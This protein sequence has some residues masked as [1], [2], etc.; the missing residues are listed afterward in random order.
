MSDL[1]KAILKRHD[2]GETVEQIRQAEGVGFGYVYSVLREHRP[3][4][5]RQPR[6][7]TSEKRKLILGLLASNIKP[8]RV[9]FLAE[10]SPAYVYALMKQEGIAA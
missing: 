1:I 5:R 7:R 8:P 10:C 2:R 3:E 9:A 6:T 4:R